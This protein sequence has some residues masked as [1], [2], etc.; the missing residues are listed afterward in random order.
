MPFSLNEEANPQRRWRFLERLISHFWKRWSLEYLTLQNGRK[1]N[2]EG[3]TAFKV[4]DLVC[5]TDEM[6]T[7]LQWPSGRIIEAYRG[8]Y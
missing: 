6:M 7:P 3:T 5:V 2:I 8:K 4:G 1:W